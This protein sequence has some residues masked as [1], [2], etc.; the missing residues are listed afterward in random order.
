MPYYRRR[1]NRAFGRVFRGQRPPNWE[2]KEQMGSNH[3]VPFV[4]N[5]YNITTLSA[6]AYEDGANGYLMR[7]ISLNWAAL[8]EG[9]D[10]TDNL[11][12]QL[13]MGIWIAT[14]PDEAGAA[15]AFTDPNY[16]M[17]R[18]KF[19]CNLTTGGTGHMWVPK[20][21]SISRD[22]SYQRGSGGSAVF[23]G[24]R[25]LANAVGSGAPS[26][27]I[28]AYHHTWEQRQLFSGR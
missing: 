26:K 23:V 14:A 20:G 12:V 2:R 27:I 11:I 15:A 19:A 6:G 9:T 5:T 28:T 3:E 1:N 13:E 17:L 16:R 21:F 24:I 18:R 8:G 25:H 10:G 22:P 7:R 4:G